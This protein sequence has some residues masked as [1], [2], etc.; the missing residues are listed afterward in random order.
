[1]TTQGNYIVTTTIAPSRP[2]PLGDNDNVR[3]HPAP[4]LRICL[5]CPQ[6]SHD[7]AQ[8]EPPDNAP[9]EERARWQNARNNYR[10]MAFAMAS[11]T[12]CTWQRRVFEEIIEGAQKC[13]ERIDDVAHAK[14]EVH[15]P[16]RK[17]IPIHLPT[18]HDAVDDPHASVE[19]E[20]DPRSLD[21][22]ALRELI[23]DWAQEQPRDRTSASYRQ[24]RDAFD[25][26]VRT[27]AERLTPQAAS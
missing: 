3:H 6:S 21:D 5:A 8:L 25:L 17:R 15:W 20:I 11:M 12:V 19:Y 26:L 10:G 24:W 14:G 1:M 16:V 2:M 23:C 9:P 18:T 27:L 4:E 13:I 22:S 7:A